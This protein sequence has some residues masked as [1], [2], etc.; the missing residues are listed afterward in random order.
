[1]G[2]TGGAILERTRGVRG[3]S[4]PVLH[5]KCLSHRRTADR[6]CR[7]PG[8]VAGKIPS[9]VG[10]FPHL[11]WDGFGSVPR[12]LACVGLA[13]GHSGTADAPACNVVLA[14]C[15]ATPR[16]KA[17]TALWR[18]RSAAR[19]GVD[20]RKRATAARRS[21]GSTFLSPSMATER[22]SSLA[23]RHAGA[24]SDVYSR[25]RSCSARCVIAP[26]HWATASGSPLD[27]CV[28]RP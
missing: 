3:C 23:A 5:A 19:F 16:R 28:N 25:Q 7:N 8:D 10:D 26:N 15:M 14:T 27:Q 20:S 22:G 11:R 9:A 18:G 4:H 1:M 2:K 24:S 13:I 21:R 17:P 6:M 12:L